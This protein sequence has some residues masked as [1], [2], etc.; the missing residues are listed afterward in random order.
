MRTWMS[1]NPHTSLQCGVADPCP[2]RRA[3]TP[4]NTRPKKCANARMGLWAS[5]RTALP[6]RA[7]GGR[8]RGQPSVQSLPREGQASQE[9]MLM[10]AVTLTL[11]LT[12]RNTWG[13]RGSGCGQL[14]PHGLAAPARACTPA[15]APEAAPPAPPPGGREAGPSPKPGAGAGQS[16]EARSAPCPH[17]EEALSETRP[18]PRAGPPCE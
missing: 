5:C 4:T 14:R 10:L 12:L 2:Q 18:W 13:P 16:S 1:L 3:M 6:G 15:P 8:R 17:R 11:T 9:G 7:E